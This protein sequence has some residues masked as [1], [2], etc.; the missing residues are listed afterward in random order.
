MGAFFNPYLLS[1]RKFDPNH[2]PWKNGSLFCIFPKADAGGLLKDNRFHH[3]F[4][5]R[6]AQNLKQVGRSVFLHI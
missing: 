2:F 4:L 6:S 1:S 3:C 5:L